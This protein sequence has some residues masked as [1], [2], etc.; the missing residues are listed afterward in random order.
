[1]QQAQQRH[2]AQPLG[3]RL[4]AGGLK[5]RAEPVAPRA[6]R[7]AVGLRRRILDPQGPRHETERVGQ[8]DQR[9]QHREAAID[10]CDRQLAFAHLPPV[11]ADERVGQATQITEKQLDRLADGRGVH[12]VSLDKAAEVLEVGLA[13]GE[14]SRVAF[15][16]KDVEE[17]GAIREGRQHGTGFGEGRHGVARMSLCLRSEL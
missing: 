3:P 9:T 6:V 5:H 16:K 13:G 12:R 17:A 15:G 8:L 4:R 2:I 14:G 7:V 11:I 10:R 1:V